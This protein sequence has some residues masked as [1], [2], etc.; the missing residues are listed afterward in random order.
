MLGAAKARQSL[1]DAEQATALFKRVLDERPHDAAALHGLGELALHEGRLEEAISRLEASL[2]SDPQSVATRY[3]LVQALQQS[4]RGDQTAVHLQRI[5]AARTGL[6]KLQNLRDELSKEP[7]NPELRHQIA[8]LEY[9]YG[10]RDDAVLMYLSVLDLEPHHT[11]THKALALHYGQ[12][13]R[14]D[15]AFQALAEYHAGLTDD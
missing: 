15:P 5:E 6:S 3:L 14:H 12:L 1:G 2:Q 4:G 10:S 11:P 13:A 9:A 8:A 7:D